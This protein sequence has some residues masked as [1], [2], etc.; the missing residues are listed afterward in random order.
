MSDQE[1]VLVTGE[2]CDI[3]DAVEHDG[4]DLVDLEKG[5]GLGSSLP[6]SLMVDRQDD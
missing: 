3:V 1:K 6:I 5:I 4:C 2:S